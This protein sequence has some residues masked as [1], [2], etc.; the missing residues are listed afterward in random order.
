MHPYGK[1]HGGTA[2][3]IKSNIKR[4]EIPNGIV[5]DY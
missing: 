5:A 3:I 1:A 4:Y 2:L